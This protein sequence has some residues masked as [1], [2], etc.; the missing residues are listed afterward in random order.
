MRPFV[1]SGWR[2]DDTQIRR[3]MSDLS[4]IAHLARLPIEAEPPSREEPNQY[5]RGIS[6]RHD[7][8]TGAMLSTYA[9]GPKDGLPYG[10]VT[11]KAV[12]PEGSEIVLNQP[13]GRPGGEWGIDP[14]DPTS[15]TTWLAALA[16]TSRRLLDDPT[17]CRA[18]DHA[19]VRRHWCIMHHVG[20]MLPEHV[21][22]SILEIRGSSP[23][24]PP[25]L[26]LKES[27]GDVP[28]WRS[29]GPCG[30]LSEEAAIAWTSDLPPV[31]KIR[32]MSTGGHGFYKMIR[33]TMDLAGSPYHKDPMGLLR[34]I[35]DLEPVDNPLRLDLLEKPR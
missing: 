11:H 21:D 28:H 8:S 9:T 1:M 33:P 25:H 29:D 22:A 2:M 10:S 24:Q 17:G 15:D 20:S 14:D 5:E 12:T 16:E 19:L 27:L 3:T 4:T 13:F 7:L 23:M 26:G 35:N 6:V 18:A 31:L 34:D 32:G 30:L